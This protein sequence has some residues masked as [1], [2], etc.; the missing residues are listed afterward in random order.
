MAL[1]NLF[2][3]YPAYAGLKQDVNHQKSFFQEVIEKDITKAITDNDGTLDE[4]D[5]AKIRNY[6][7][8]GVPAIVGEGFCT[9]RQIPMSHQERTTSTYQGALTGLYDD[10][11][12]KTNIGIEGIREM[13]D[14]PGIYDAKT[15]LERLFIRFLLQVHENLPD[16]AFFNKAFNRVFDAQIESSKQAKD[17]LSYE[18]IKEIT[19]KKGGY[20]LLFYRSAFGHEMK[21]G[22]EKALYQTGAVMQLGNDIFDIYKDERDSI[23]TLVSYCDVIEEPRSIFIDKLKESIRL[24]KATAYQPDGIQNY[25]RKYILG[26]S[27]CF[28]ALDQLERLQSNSEGK[29]MP[30]LYS[31]KDM[32]CDMEKPQ[33]I[34][35][36]ARYYLGSDI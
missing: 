24:I 17:E 32:I 6:Y 21:E 23:K 18:Q 15:S 16:K 2:S 31:R 33:N 22:E 10:F 8:F 19:F 3:I 11:F 12:D 35:R 14:Q 28:V 5:F 9:L 4:E 20:S 13:M 26:I 7:G 1:K 36:S 27:R 25:L 34:I 29:F 30:A